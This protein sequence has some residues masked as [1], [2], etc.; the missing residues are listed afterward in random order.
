M[1]L[2]KRLNPAQLGKQAESSH[3]P[4]ASVLH[5][6]ELSSETSHLIHAREI[7]CINHTKRETGSNLIPHLL[8]A[9]VS[10]V[11]RA[12]SMPADAQNG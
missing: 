11:P 4:C 12:C 1:W 3:S 2:H 8:F 6:N 9:A 7:P 10:K 5:R